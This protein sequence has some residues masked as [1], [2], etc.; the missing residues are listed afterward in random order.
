MCRKPIITKKSFLAVLPGTF[1]VAQ[2]IAAK[3][4][5]SCN[6]VCKFMRKP[7]N[8]EWIEKVIEE[9]NYE[10]FNL[11]KGTHLEVLS[12]G[13]TESTKRMRNDPRILSLQQKSADTI[14]NKIG[15]NYGY[16]DKQIVDSNVS[17]TLFNKE[18]TDEQVKEH[19]D[20]VFNK[21]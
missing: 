14:I 19:L 16:T 21:D 2:R 8:K 18:L 6:S 4:K 10:A 20:K 5:V 17:G 15:H 9:A 13:H 7:E 3:L 12:L 1:G 11:A